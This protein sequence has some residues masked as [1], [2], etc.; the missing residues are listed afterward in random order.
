MWQNY[1]KWKRGTFSTASG[2]WENP[3]NDLAIREHELLHTKGNANW[4]WWHSSFKMGLRWRPSRYGKW[5]DRNLQS[6]IDISLVHNSPSRFGRCLHCCNHKVGDLIHVTNLGKEHPRGY[7]WM[8]WPT[9]SKFGSTLNLL[10]NAITDPFYATKCCLFLFT[11]QVKFLTN[12]NKNRKD[13]QIQVTFRAWSTH[14]MVRPIISM[15]TWSPNH[16]FH[17]CKSLRIPTRGRTQ[18]TM[19]RRGIIIPRILRNCT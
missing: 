17:M 3:W 2:I 7:Y 14:A 12:P 13:L 1:I 5:D 16:G 19:P 6:S 11:T 10:R 15:E 8:R 9:C 4:V 18:L